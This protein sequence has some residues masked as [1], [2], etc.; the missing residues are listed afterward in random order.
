M[1]TVVLSFIMEASFHLRVKQRQLRLRNLKY[2][3]YSSQLHIYISDV[4]SCKCDFITHNSDFISYKC[5]FHP[6]NY[7]IMSRKCDIVSPKCDFIHRPGLNLI[8]D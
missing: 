5:I 7:D 4:I 1:I 3:L 8:L 6:H 2:W